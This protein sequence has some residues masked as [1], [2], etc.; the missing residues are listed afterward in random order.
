M[1]F[2]FVFKGADNQLKVWIEVH[3][4]CT[5][6]EC[7]VKFFSGSAP[8][9]CFLASSLHS[10]CR[11]SLWTNLLPATCINAF[12]GILRYFCSV[13]LQMMCKGGLHECG[14]SEVLSSGG[15]WGHVPPE[16]VEN[17]GSPKWH[18]LHFE[19]TLID[20]SWKVTFKLVCLGLKVGCCDIHVN[21]DYW[22]FSPKG[23]MITKSP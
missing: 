19:S 13:S 2:Y 5:S 10:G 8:F 17:L 7:Q 12:R 14:V 1:H 16:N 23:H 20:T 4:Y 6:G 15:V 9:S 22:W 21:L 18:F 11:D 3:I